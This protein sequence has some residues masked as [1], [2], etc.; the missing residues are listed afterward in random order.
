[1]IWSVYSYN[2]L[3]LETTCVQSSIGSSRTLMLD[4]GFQMMLQT[5]V[6]TGNWLRPQ[7]LDPRLLDDVTD[8]SKNWKLTEIT[9]SSQCRSRRL[10]DTMHASKVCNHPSIVENARGWHTLQ[11]FVLHILSILI[12]TSNVLFLAGSKTDIHQF[13]C[14]SFS[15][16]IQ[17]C[18]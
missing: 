10:P 8:K 6:R 13:W 14:C 2:Y 17:C 12:Q 11:F 16:G 18:P 7:I 3:A 1:M 4:Q 9:T 15:T 5:R